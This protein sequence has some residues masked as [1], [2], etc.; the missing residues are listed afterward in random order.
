MR[1]EATGVVLDEALRMGSN[2]KPDKSSVVDTEAL[3]VLPDGVGVSVLLLL[4]LLLLVL[5]LVLVLVRAALLLAPPRVVWVEAVETKPMGVTT[6]LEA[7]LICLVNVDVLTMVAAMVSVSHLHASHCPSIQ[8][9][10]GGMPKKNAGDCL[11][12]EDPVH[13]SLL[14][15][16]HTHSGGPPNV[17]EG[18]LPCRQEDLV[19][20]LVVVPAVVALACGVAV[21]IGTVVR[22]VCIG[23][24]IGVDV[25]GVTATNVVV[26]LV[27]PVGVA[28]TNP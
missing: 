17:A 11:Q 5:V 23:V 16:T 3:T 1:P 24:A 27:A 26:V 22:V 14:L 2:P 10:L 4:L 25:R 12:L 20:V 8:Y 9:V 7:V 15:A 18:V 21:S 19:V 6:C 13:T 28:S